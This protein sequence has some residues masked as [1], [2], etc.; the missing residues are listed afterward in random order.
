M[1]V[2]DLA[3]RYQ[4]IDEPMTPRR[5][6]G[7]PTADRHAPSQ[8]PPAS[9][10]TRDVSISIGEDDIRER[11]Q[12]IEEL[13]ELELKEK[14]YQLRQRFRDLNEKTRDFECNRMQF[15][16]TRGALV[17]TS[18]TPKGLRSTLLRHTR[19]SQSTSHLVP[20]SS[21]APAMTSSQP[22]G[23]QSPS[24]SQP[25]SPLP[26]KDH[27]PFCGCGTCSIAKYKMPDVTP[28]A[29]DLRPPEPPIQ[30]RPEKPKGWI[31]RLSMP[32]VGAAFLLDAKKNASATSLKLGLSS[33]AEN[34]RRRKDS[35]EQGIGNRTIG[36]V[37]R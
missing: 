25:T 17:G 31:R 33:P 24:R 5:S 37:R 13:A 19:G 23:S 12:R 6:N 8:D 1:S 16:D 15:L 21:S 36:M 20:P 26:A 11:R 35:F 3:S 14:E 4:P 29:H 18:E 32:A 2:S 34:S 10:T 30:L 22:Q 28:S 27:A 7:S 9:Q